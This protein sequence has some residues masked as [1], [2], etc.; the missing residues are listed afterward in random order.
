MDI[1]Q[2]HTFLAIAAH[3]SFL[4]ASE[5]LHI[6]QSTVSTRIRN[7]EE[8]LGTRLFE[9][10]RTG[11][12]L[13]PAGKR[14]VPHAKTLV[15]TVDQALHDLGLPHQFRAS[16]RIAGRVALWSDFLP[17]WVGWMREQAP[18]VSVQSDIGFEDDLV[19]RL[20]EGTL[21]IALMYTPKH[22]PGLVVEGLFDDTLVLAS[23]RADT[24]WPD[25]DYV[26]VDWGPG[27][28]AWHHTSFPDL[29]TSAQRASIGWL[30]A[31]IIL[32]NGGSCF[33][34][35]RMARREFDSGTLFPVPGAASFTLPAYMVYPRHVDNDVLATAVDGLR[36]VA[37]G[38]PPEDREPP[39]G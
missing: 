36:E 31:Q 26:Y 4:A 9:R 10:D 2:A 30:G 25:P 13:T 15:L 27:F 37:A 22:V 32:R 16:L 6:T 28:Y 7:L 8:E 18:D 33:L 20:V 14:F 5:Q 1:V 11:A 24:A 39:P 23:T 29:E 12:R 3:G 38:L 34:P 19:R 35:F 17:A 21:D